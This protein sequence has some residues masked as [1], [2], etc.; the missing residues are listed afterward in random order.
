MIAVGLVVYF[1]LPKQNEEKPPSADPPPLAGDITKQVHEFCGKCHAYPPADSFP[2]SAWRE[3]VEQ[4]YRFFKDDLTLSTQAPNFEDVVKYYEDRA[5]RQLPAIKAARATTPLPVTFTRT[6]Y[7]V[8]ANAH[9]PAI[10]NVSL[11]HLFDKERL[12]VLACEMRH[13]LVMALSPY[14]P[15]PKWRILYKAPKDARFHPAHAEVVDLEGNGKPGILVANL[16]SFTPTDNRD[17]SVVW[18]RPTGKDQFTPITL[19]ER[20]GRVADVQAYDFRNV[21]KKDLVVA[22]FGWRNTGEIL[23]L[24]N[25]TTDWSRPKFVP[26]P[27]PLDERHGAIHVPVVPK[28]L[29]GS[30]HSDI[31][32]LVSQEHETVVAFLNDGHGNFKR[33]TIFT[34]PHPAYGSSGIQLVDFDGDGKVDVLYTNGDTL[35]KPYLLKPYHGIQWLRNTGKFPFEHHPIAPMY[36]VHRAVAADFTGTGKKLKDIVAVSFLPE[37]GFPQRKDLQLDAVLFLEQTAAGKFERHAIETVTCDHVT[38]AAGDI[39]HSGRTDVVVGQFSSL[40][41][42]HAITIWK[43][44]GA[45]K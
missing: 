17:G 36:G 7:P 25:Q 15:E 34:G 29:L 2:R 3:E 33:E 39:F 18:L 40:K 32:A 28:G 38:C 16:G 20:V 30:G 10:S 5:P 42:E 1:T 43:N 35:D 21:G 14:A 4:G 19:L 6:T 24:E 27:K 37:E 13:G 41:S 26:R 11:V 45:A 23:Y 31:V 9:P 44:E 12:D 8:P 22:V